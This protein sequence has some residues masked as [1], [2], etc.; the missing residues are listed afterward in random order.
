VVRSGNQSFP[1]PVWDGQTFRH[2][3]RGA[4]VT[5]HRGRRR[6]RE[7]VVQHMSEPLVIT[8]TGIDERLIEAGNR[9]AVH[10]LVLAVAAMDPHNQGLVA[11]LLR[12]VC[13]GWYPWLKAWLTISSVNTRAC[14]APAN[15]SKPSMPSTASYTVS[16]VPGCHLTAALRI[17]AATR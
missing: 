13:A 9:P 14:Q 8:K 10:L 12:S 7:V 4:V 6:P 16:T 5:S 17:A 15:L 1:R 2:I 11:I 3:V